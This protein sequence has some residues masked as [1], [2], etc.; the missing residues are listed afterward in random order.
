MDAHSH[1]NGKGRSPDAGDRATEHGGADDRAAIT[2]AERD[3]ATTD[4]THAGRRSGD[5][6]SPAAAAMSGEGDLQSGTVS[7]DYVIREKIGWGGCSTVYAGKHRVSGQEVAIKVMHRGLADSPRQVQRFVQEARAVHLIH[8]PTIV[9]MYDIGQLADGRPYIV[10][11]LLHGINLASLLREQGRLSPAEAFEVLAPVCES[12]SVAHGS[13]IVHRDIKASNII[14][15]ASE[16]DERRV[17]L[18]DFGIAK[19]VRSDQPG[20]MQ[21]TVGHVLGTPHSMAPEQ[22]KGKPVDGRTDIYAL[23]ALLYRLLTGRHPFEGCDALALT[24]M[25]LHAAAPLPSRFAPVPPAIDAVVR[26]CM[27]K[28]PARRY[29]D[30]P[31]LLASLR[32]AVGAERRELVSQAIGIYVEGRILEGDEPDDA[33]IDDLM[34]ILDAAEQVF[35]RHGFSVPLSTSNS[36]LGATVVPEGG[37]ADFRQR[38][39]DIAAE[40]DQELEQREDADQRVSIN[41]CLHVAAAMVKRHGAEADAD[42]EIIGGAIVDVGTWA[43]KHPVSGVCAT[44]E[45]LGMAQ[46]ESERSPRSYVRIVTPS[47][48]GY[49]A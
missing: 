34:N 21:T 16:G 41:V 14:I 28:D 23:G 13:G 7:G 24:R 26:K 37:F 5:A 20:G 3:A 9:E 43:P 49:R 22:I 2:T 46:S 10:M 48:V 39:M 38:T 31:E 33:I 42:A 11:E 45:T 47:G 27:E 32:D 30:I 12:L 25:H 44:A 19:L 8:H 40:L 17:K 29:Q 36:V 18:L 1:K 15:L 35:E 4:T 6:A